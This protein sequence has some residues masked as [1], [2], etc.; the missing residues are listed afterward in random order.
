MI[1]PNENLAV[2]GAS[3]FTINHSPSRFGA[4]SDR[5]RLVVKRRLRALRKIAAAKTIASGCREVLPEFGNKRGF[6][7]KRIYQLY[8]NY[9][10]SGCDWTTLVDRAIAGPAWYE[11]ENAVSLPDAFLDYLASEWSLRQR[12]KF[13]A[14]HASLLNQW[15]A[16]SRGYD[17]NAIPGYPLC[18]APTATGLP[19]GWTYE[20]LLRAVKPRVSKFSRKLV[21]VGPKA[22]MLAHAPHILATRYGIAPGQFYIVDDSWN[23]FKV[24]AFGQTVRLLAFHILDLASACN[25]KRG[26]KPALTNERDAEERLREREM[27]WLLVAHLTSNGY[28]EQGT[29]FIC[30][31]A[32]G[33]I[34]EHEESIL[35]DFG[36]PITVQRGP[37]GGGPGIAGLFTGPGG[38][39]PR[40]KAPLESWFNLLRNRTDHLLEFPGQTGS[41]SSGLPQPEGLPGLERDTRALLDAARAL[42]LARAELLQLGM[43]NYS[44]AIFALEKVTELINF[45]DDH[46]LEG[47]RQC[48]HI[49]TEW[50]PHV[51]AP[52][53]PA[54]ELLSEKYSQAEREAFAALIA[55]NKDLKRERNLSPAEVWYPG[56]AQLKKLS[57]HIAAVLM[58]SLDPDTE[59]TV[60]RGIL[61]VTCA[62]L[63]PD[64]PLLYGLTR[65]DGQGTDEPLRT[66][67][68]FLVRLN[69]VDPLSCYLYHADGSFAGTA[70]LYSRSSREDALTNNSS[71]QAGGA[72]TTG[73]SSQS[74]H[75]QFAEKRKWLAGQ[76]ADARFNASRVTAA[77]IARTKNNSRII[78][79][80][81]DE[82]SHFERIADEAI[83]NITP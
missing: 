50:R 71:P 58:A 31:K 8:N 17:S 21:Q 60:E 46:Q 3:P 42:P 22:A 7:A 68:K 75:R 24:L 63:S 11:T 33:T 28:R 15:R 54:T 37:R 55:A 6:S 59:A 36:L 49:V 41:F 66:G 56:A 72:A 30:E 23:D 38:G 26:Y 32:T 69:R 79:E 51:T 43:L 62:E 5:A 25:V 81:A 44:D 77:D 47:W 40:W 19:L 27:I 83:A 10:K 80:N 45:R 4:L 64:E 34:R 29:T 74:L 52:W 65:R 57:P 16:W 12:D 73:H 48:G 78:A 18:P 76:T 39:N 82:K 2:L 13:K 20:N 70:K 67:E 9:I 14:V 53:L 35:H 1:T 61:P